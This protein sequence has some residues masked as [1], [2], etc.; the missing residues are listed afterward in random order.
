ME[1]KEVKYTLK[2]KFNFLYE[3][4]MP[5]GAKFRRDLLVIVALIVAAIFICL[6]G[7]NLM[8]SAAVFN[9]INLIEVFKWILII[10]LVVFSI[11]FIADLVLRSLQYKYI[12]Y[13]FYDDSLVYEDTFLNQQ[14]KTIRYENIKEIELRRTI[15]DR[16]MGYGILII[17]TNAEG[18][19]SAGMVIY[20]IKNIDE[21]YE[22]IDKLVYSK[23]KGES[24]ELNNISEQTTS[25]SATPQQEVQTIKEEPLNRAP[26]EQDEGEKNFKDS[27]KNVK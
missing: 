6:F 4:F 10:A 17:S 3:F 1:N 18:K 20:A 25:P 2:P 14:A 11:K 5:L 12:S 22:K 26:Q 16:I 19:R 23:R 8:E 13:K 7:N 9:G 15:W 27:L 24:K 21:A